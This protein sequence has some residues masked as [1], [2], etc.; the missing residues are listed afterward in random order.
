MRVLRD[1]GTGHVIGY[2]L[3]LLVDNRPCFGTIEPVSVAPGAN[4]TK[5]GFQ[6]YDAGAVAT[7]SFRASHPG[8]YA[9][10]DFAVA[11]VAT[12]LPS[13]TARGLVDAAAANGYGRSGDLFTKTPTVVTLLNDALPAGETPCT[14]AAFAESLHVAAL[15]TNGYDR[16]SG[17]DAPRP[18]PA[19][20]AAPPQIALRAFAITPH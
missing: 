16:L 2:R 9:S 6:E 10:F 7:I 3:I 15:A 20:P 4:D 14:R 13:V 19:H 5:C 1:L 11:R 8:N 17:L 18:D 12:A